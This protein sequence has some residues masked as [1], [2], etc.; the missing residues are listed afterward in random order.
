MATVSEDDLYSQ[1]QAES[2][3]TGQQIPC[4]LLNPKFITVLTRGH[5]W[6]LSWGSWIQSS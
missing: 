3:L 1:L 4:L 2:H 6:T 5:Q